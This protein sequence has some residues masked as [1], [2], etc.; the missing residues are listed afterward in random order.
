MTGAA[1][2][3]GSQLAA[4][5][6]DRGDHV[7]G[8]DL[9]TDYYEV[10]QKEANVAALRHDRFEFARHD[11]ANGFDE[12]AADADVVFHLAGQPGVRASWRQQFDE[13]LSRNV[14]ATQRVLEACSQSGVARLVYASSSS[15][16]GNA[17]QYPVDEAMRPKPY[18][19]YGVT[20]LA[21]EQLCTLYGQ[22]FD[23]SVASLRYFTVYGP[24][25]RPDM[26]TY[27][28]FEAA[29]GGP[30]FPLFGDGQQ[31]RDF[32]Y[33]GDVVTAN[34][35]AAEADLQPGSV[36]N[37]AG[38]GDHSMA[39]LIE[40]VGEVTGRPVPVDR[41]DQ[42]RGDVSRT[43][44]TTDLARAALG[45]QPTTDLRT[46]LERQHQWHL[47]RRRRA[48]ELATETAR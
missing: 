42:E 27:R 20:K 29:L 14:Q 37:V 4:A 23:L 28:L 5:C 12:F 7:V 43:G 31:R 40:L 34:L 46:G 10:E 38:G 44:A 30:I 9:M 24:G 35:A 21:G 45:W 3:I 39:D 25:Q 19:P 2:F 13:Y 26:A 32:T 11:L 16:Y 8:V 17:D 6:L 41:R 33:V 47:E 1:G 36:F 22:N 18:S 48:G 15:I